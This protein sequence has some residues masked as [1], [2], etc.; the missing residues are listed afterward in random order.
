MRQQQ[1]TSLERVLTALDHREPDRVPFFL[2]VTLQGARE[3]GMTPRDYY[4]RVEHVVQ[5]QLYLR[6]KYRHDNLDNFFY[7][8]LE[9]EAW[10]QEVVFYE[11]GPPNAGAAIIENSDQILKLEPPSVQGNPCLQRVLETTRQL[12][13]QAGNEAPVMGV[14]VSPFSLPVLQ[15]GFGPYLDLIYEQSSLFQRLMEVNEHFAVEWANAQLQAGATA[16]CYFDPVSSPGIIPRELYLETGYPVASRTLARIQG[17]TATH[18]ASGRCL[19]LIP[20]VAATGTS[21]IGISAEEDL[22]VA[23]EKCRGRLT[24]LGNLNG[25]EMVRWDAGQASREVQRA[26][27]RGAPGGGFVLS[28]NHGEIPW[29]VSEEVLGAISDTVLNLGHYPLTLED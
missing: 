2:P 16:I 18:F 6:D 29:Q 10:G 7:A 26:M 15:M 5:A 14:V 19:E 13:L 20:E 23:K 12:K 24:V 8:A 22:A 21:V 28:D 1:M 27:A 17:P 3:M 9:V 11:E 25:L 4:S